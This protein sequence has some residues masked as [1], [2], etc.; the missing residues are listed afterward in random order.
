M[1]GGVVLPSRYRFLEQDGRGRV[2]KENNVVLQGASFRP[3]VG[4]TRANA[5]NNGLPIDLQA[6]LDQIDDEIFEYADRKQNIESMQGWINRS[7][8]D[9]GRR[10]AKT[11]IERRQN[12]RNASNGNS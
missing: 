10:Q 4:D 2:T 8:F 1:H 9:M 3:E 7:D 11:V 5:V 12:L 6:M